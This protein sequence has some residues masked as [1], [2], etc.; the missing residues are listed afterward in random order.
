LFG[1]EKG[2]MPSQPNAA[3]SL[4]LAA[5]LASIKEYTLKRHASDSMEQQQTEILM[6]K[7][8]ADTL[9]LNFD[10]KTKLPMN[11]F[12]QP[13]AIDLDKKVIVEAYAHIG[14]LKGAQNNK[15][16]GDILK[17]IFIE[18]KLGKGWKKILCFADEAVAKYVLSGS[19]VA[20][21]VRTF[22]IEVYVMH[23]PEE[24]LECIRSAQK[25]QRMVNPD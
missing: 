10:N 5:A 7:M 18:E 1:W 4:T 8:L 19:W 15:V 6:L 23:L 12:V 21:A 14:A 22:G 2:E 3:L 25:R 16:K 13:D 20:E 11:I 17:L 24:Q 9:D